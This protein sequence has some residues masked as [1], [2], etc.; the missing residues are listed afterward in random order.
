MLLSDVLFKYSA[1]LRIDNCAK[2]AVDEVRTPRQNG[3]CCY[4]RKYRIIL[5]I[6]MNVS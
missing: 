1:D 5:L 2:Y 6:N 3:V 4:R